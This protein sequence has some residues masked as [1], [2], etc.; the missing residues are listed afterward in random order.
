MGSA[1]VAED[2]RA[3]LGLA[4]DG[5][6]AMKSVWVAAVMSMMLAVPVG[7]AAQSGAGPSGCPIT[8]R[9]FDPA[10]VDLSMQNTSGKTIVGMSFYA[11]VA[12]ATEHWKWMHWDWDDSKALREFGW[13]KEI[14]PGAKKRLTWDGSMYSEHGGGG[15]LVLTS[16][17]FSDGT[18]WEEA[19]DRANCKVL[20]YDQHKK[21]FARAVE[22]PPRQ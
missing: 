22:L 3:E 13:N 16:V 10:S 14:K 12:D 7:A 4:I 17:L 9:W 15:A 11:A 19:P 1:G 20:W 6:L 2:G 5:E 8:M 21:M 18:S